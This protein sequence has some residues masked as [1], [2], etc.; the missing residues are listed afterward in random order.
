MKKQYAWS[1]EDVGIEKP[2]DP[3]EIKKQKQIDRYHSDP[4]YRE[5]VK[6][7][8]RE[9][10]KAEHLSRYGFDPEYTENKRASSR[11]WARKKAAAKKAK[12]GSPDA[13][14]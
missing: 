14:N 9:R 4:E 13:S 6:A 1:W 11:E 3:Y 10:M 7:K 8:M 5:R 2:V 12:G